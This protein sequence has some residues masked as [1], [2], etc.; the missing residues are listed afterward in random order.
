MNHV[1]ALI[2]MLVAAA[3]PGLH[4]VEEHKAAYAGGTIASLN[5]KGRRIGG[6]IDTSDPG[7]FVFIVSRSRTA[8]TSVRIRPSS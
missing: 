8:T 1:T 4:A 3:S 6:R 5:A 7:R 2:L